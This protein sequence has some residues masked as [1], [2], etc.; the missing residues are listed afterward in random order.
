MKNVNYNKI[1]IESQ[2]L[3]RNID[4]MTGSDA[5]EEIIKII[6][7]MNLFS[8]QKLD[9]T[10]LKFF[11]TDKVFPK[12]DFFI[13]DYIKL[14]DITI[15]QILYLFSDVDFESE[16][17]RGRLFET[18]L[19]RVFTSGLGQ[20][21]TPR[22][23]VEFI[24]GF[25]HKKNLIPKNAL[26][27]DPACGSSGILLSARNS[28]T[29]KIVGYDINERLVRVSKMNMVLHGIEN[30]EINNQSFLKCPN[31]EIYDVCITNP[32]FGVEEKQKNILKEFILGHDKKSCDLEILFIEKILK[33]LKPGGI[34]GIVL[35]DGVFNNMTSI[36]LREYILQHSNIIA[37][38]D[39][40]EN[41]F[42]SSGTG[43]E[44]GILFFRK[45]EN[46]I[47]SQINFEAY[48]INFVGYETQTKF[49]K[50]IPKNDLKDILN[51]VEGI[52]KTIVTGL[53]STKRFDGKYYFRKEKNKNKLIMDI[54]ENS[55]KKIV[56]VYKNDSEII[57]YIQYTDIDPV[58]GIIKSYTEMEVSEAPSRAKIVINTGDILIPKLKQSSD[59]IAI[60][61]EEFDG[62]VATNGFKV[63]RPK[64][65][66]NSE[67][68]FALFR[69]KKI[70]EQLQDYSSGTI[71]PSIDDDHFNEIVFI[72]GD[73]NEDELTKKVK[74]IFELIDI[75]KNKMIELNSSMK[76]GT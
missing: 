58:F 48:K 6:F 32:P 45:K 3:I 22:E 62:C 68:V 25:L 69:D 64:N 76:M 61:T 26:I 37:S 10:S 44:T 14:K 46:N 74:E 28:E 72:D 66:K 15:E 20:F 55:G 2:D 47:E 1:V 21:F 53:N 5:F 71:M 16:D 33:V 56:D 18:Y 54:F 7:T 36:K 41:V 38:V 31:E 42:K 34:C 40:P 50:K 57:R 9:S 11:Y 67:L 52:Q 19:G 4:G 63:I 65:G 12:Y 49:A 27:L 60:V 30:Y 13:G 75:A 39:L 17:I 8:T 70:Q 51:D 23:I 59:K 29:G 35:P 73:V 43:C 24:T